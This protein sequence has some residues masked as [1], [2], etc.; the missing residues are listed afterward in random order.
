MYWND[1]YN[2]FDA[3]YHSINI[4]MRCIEIKTEIERLLD[5]GGLTLTW[6]VL[7]LC[8]YGSFAADRNRLT[9]TWDVLK[10]SKLFGID[11]SRWININ[12]RCIEMT[13]LCRFQMA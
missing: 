13:A 9:L 10:L 4:N 6:D 11:T 1:N 8:S 5:E 2:P 3:R 7:K 12:M